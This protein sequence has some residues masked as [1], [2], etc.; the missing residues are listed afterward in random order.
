MSS[1][2]SNVMSGPCCGACGARSQELAGWLPFYL[3]GSDMATSIWQCHDCGTYTRDINLDDPE[4]RRHF[5]VA[6]YTDPKAEQRYRSVRIGY[7]EY[8]ADLLSTRL[9]KQLQGAR[10]LDFGC[11]FGHFLEVL[12]DR[13]AI[14]EGVEITSV[15]RESAR[16]RGLTV[17]G[18]IPR[19]QDALYDIIVAIDSLYYTN[20]PVAELTALRTVLKPSG[21]LLIRVTNRV[22]YLDLLRALGIAVHRDHFGDAKFNFSPAGTLRLLSRSGFNTREVIWTEMGKADP[23]LHIRLFYILSRFLSDNLSLNW[24]AGILVVADTGSGD[25]A[26][27]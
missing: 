3:P 16:Q 18:Q 1:S 10:I 23:R 13:G 8:L 6:S 7:F 26:G 21:L 20:D 5:D 24:T 15:P 17:H 25:S 11:S 14:P 27:L 2:D 19:P 9:G 4:L 12:R 22:W